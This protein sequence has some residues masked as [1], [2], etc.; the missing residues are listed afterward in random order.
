MG[1]SR[2]KGHLVNRV[3]VFFDEGQEFLPSL[4]VQPQADKDADRDPRMASRSYT[5][6]RCSPKFG[7]DSRASPN[8]SGPGR[9]QRQKAASGCSGPLFV[10]FP[11]A[12]HTMSFP[13]ESC[14]LRYDYFST[15]WAFLPPPQGKTMSGACQFAGGSERSS[16]KSLRQ[17]LPN[18]IVFHRRFVLCA[19]KRFSSTRKALYPLLQKNEIFTGVPAFQL[20][21]DRVDLL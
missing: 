11:L 14:R 17:I 4:F 13:V 16:W 9:G 3:L 6:S 1:M 8:G 12:V 5:V 21:F 19:D 10:M 7:S 18:G 15:I 20:D 2:K